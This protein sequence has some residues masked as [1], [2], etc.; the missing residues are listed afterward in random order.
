M[1]DVTRVLDRPTYGATVDGEL[2]VEVITPFAVKE[3]T[4]GIS[5]SD[6]CT[7]VNDDNAVV[8]AAGASEDELSVATDIIETLDA[9]NAPYEMG[10]KAGNISLELDGGMTFEVDSGP[11]VTELGATG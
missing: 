6:D 1:G 9:G 5:V 8:G 4:A 11:A 2:S 7:I 3:L 10:V